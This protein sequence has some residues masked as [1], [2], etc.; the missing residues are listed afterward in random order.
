[1][2]N[3]V[4]FLIRY[5]Y[6]GLFLLLEFVCFSLIVRYNQSQR[7]IWVNSVHL[8]ASKANSK[9]SNVNEYFDLRTAN[10]S[11]S[12]ENSALIE[13]IIN[14]KIY[15]ADNTYQEYLNAD[16]IGY[17][18]IPARVS[19]KVI[20]QRNNFFTINKGKLDGVTPDMG[21]ITTDGIVGTI[22]ACSDHYSKVMLVLNN[23]SQ[24]SSSILGTE[25]FGNLKWDTSSN[26][27][28]S[29][30]AIPKYAD[31]SVGDTIVTSGY[32]TIFPRGI[33]IGKISGF[34][35]PEGS[36]NYR[37]NIELMADPTLT[38]RVYIVNN[39]YAEEERMLLESGEDGL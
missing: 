28:M 32:S 13:E 39:I 27:S 2:Q 15:T 10:D 34:E 23:L 37:V 4:K 24:I 30:Y 3:L 22:T 33:M 29:L 6:L 1:M 36:N 14:Y 31:I 19:S 7:E 25:Y 17:Q 12:Q 5:G 35:I 8:Y 16:S 11:I 38:D 18:V 20:N 26:R 9:S 21:V